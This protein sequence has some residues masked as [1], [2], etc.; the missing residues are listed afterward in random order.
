[1]KYGRSVGLYTFVYV[2]ELGCLFH[3]RQRRERTCAPVGRG[4]KSVEHVGDDEAE[5]NV[6][7]IFSPSEVLKD[8]HT[9]LASL[10]VRVMHRWLSLGAGGYVFMPHGKTLKHF[11]CKEPAV[12]ASFVEEHSV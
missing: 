5:M 1:M 11:K 6:W 8:G 2:L 9:I 4:Y 3:L 7:L 12:D 10:I